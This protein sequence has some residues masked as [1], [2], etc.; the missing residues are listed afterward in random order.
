MYLILY[1]FA[2]LIAKFYNNRTLV[3]IVRVLG[4]SLPISAFNSIQ[5]A[6]IARNLAFKKV[7]FSTSVA[8]IISGAIG[9]GLAYLKFGVWAL[10]F[11]YLCNSLFSCIVLSIQIPWRPQL[12]FSKKR[13]IPLIQYGWKVM[14]SSFIGTF[15]AQLRSLI[16]GH[17]YTAADLAFYNRGQQFPTLISNNIDT[18]ISSVLFPYMSKFSDN[19]VRLKQ[20]VRRSMRAS[21]YLIMPAMFGLAAVTK[22][23]ILLLLTKKWLSAVPYMQWL[24]IA[25][26]F[27]TITNTNL[28]VMSASGRSDLLLKI[29]LIKKPVYL[30]LLFLAIK[31]GVLAIAITMLIYS[32]YATIVNMKPNKRLINYSYIEQFKDIGPSLVLSVL[33]FLIVLFVEILNLP[34]ILTLIFQILIGVTFYV[35]C[36]YI[37]KIDAFLYLLKKLRDVKS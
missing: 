20:V 16:I 8:T 27:T 24:S 26:A 25:S 10:V 36:S 23:L 34:A 7:F 29:E 1:I 33:M 21:T 32:I 4:L 17:F 5:Q 14:A 15:F 37:F 3:P 2:P 30:I 19:P 31:L 11:Q 22:P 28:Q 13:A 9:I 35:T 6:Y 12:I 18:T